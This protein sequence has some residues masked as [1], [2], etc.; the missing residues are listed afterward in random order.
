M[1]EVTSKKGIK[2]EAQSEGNGVLIFLISMLF[3]Y[4][5]IIGHYVCDFR[6]SK[7]LKEKSVSWA[8]VCQ[9][10]SKHKGMQTPGE[11]SGQWVTQ[12]AEATVLCE[13]LFLLLGNVS[14]H[15]WSHWNT[16][17]GRTLCMHWPDHYCSWVWDKGFALLRRG[18]Q[19]PSWEC[20]L[21][22]THHLS[23]YQNGSVSVC[24]VH[25]WIHIPLTFQKGYLVR[26]LVSISIRKNVWRIS[27]SYSFVLGFFL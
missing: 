22:C 6:N 15:H 20:R 23:P 26:T 14:C 21:E 24:P 3:D 2:G 8:E 13:G 11:K 9:N 19:G 25:I 12:C 18:L 1:T 5:I 17:Q 27:L 16:T 4:I 7:S 10:C